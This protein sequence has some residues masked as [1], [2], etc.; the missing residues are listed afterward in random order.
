M[1]RVLVAFLALFSIFS[2]VVQLD[3]LSSVFGMA[4]V[5]LLAIDVLV[6]QFARTPQSSRMPDK[7]LA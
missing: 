1:L 5:L 4:A 6:A 3:A 2:L 7:P